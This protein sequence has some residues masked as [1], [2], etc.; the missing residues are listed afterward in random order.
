MF[1][2]TRYKGV[3]RHRKSIAAVRISGV[4]RNVLKDD[5]SLFKATLKRI[6]NNLAG[7]DIYIYTNDHLPAHYHA[8]GD[9][10]EVKINIFECSLYKVVND[11]KLRKSII[12]KLLEWTRI[13]RAMLLSEWNKT[14]A[15]NVGVVNLK[16]DA[17]R[18]I[19]E[20]DKSVFITKI[21]L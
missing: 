20:Q 3:I 2:R 7:V 8:R 9:G 18:S 19:S 16:R 6:P 10:F 13:N 14:R 15:D 11:G 12:K 1:S 21:Y 5:T 4:K 17:K